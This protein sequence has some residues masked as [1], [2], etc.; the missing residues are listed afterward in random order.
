MYET[1]NGL[2]GLAALPIPFH[3]T[4]RVIGSKYSVLTESWNSGA[5]VDCPLDPVWDLLGSRKVCLFWLVS[6]LFF[7]AKGIGTS[8]T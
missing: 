6:V 8:N 5:T 7:L 1:Q 2:N 4:W 3:V